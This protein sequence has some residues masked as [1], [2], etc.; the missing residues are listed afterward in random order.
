MP[1]SSVRAREVATVSTEGSE[2][3]GARVKGQTLGASGLVGVTVPDFKVKGCSERPSWV[4]WHHLQAVTW[5]QV[6][7]LT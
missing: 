7:T 4:L 1:P 6:V 3:P 5:G 2:A